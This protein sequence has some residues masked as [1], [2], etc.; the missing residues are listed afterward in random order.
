M[1]APGYV[2]LLLAFVALPV[3]AAPTVTAVKVDTA[4]R[5]DGRLTDACWQ[6]PAPIRDFVVL[7]QTKSAVNQTEAWVAYDADNLYLAVRAWDKDMD[8]LRATV[9]DRD[10]RVF[11]D[12]CLE[13]FIDTALDRFHFLHFACNPLGAQYD[14][15]G[16]GA[17]ESG[18]WNGVWSV[19]TA[20]AA[21]AWT[22]EFAIPFGTLGLA[23]GTGKTWGL[24]LCRTRPAEGELS[25]WSQTGGKFAVPQSFGNVNL[26][27]DWTP[28][29]VSLSVPQWGECV[30]GR[31]SFQCTVA[32]L[33]QKARDLT[34]DLEVSSPAEAPRTIS[35]PLNL[36]VGASQTLTVT[37]PIFQQGAHNLALTVADRAT[38][39]VV[40][41]VGCTKLVADMAAFSILK[42]FYRD[43]VTVAYTLR[44]PAE[45]LGR[46]G[47]AAELRRS[48]EAA[49]LATKRL[50]S[51]TER[52]GEIRFDTTSLPLGQYE[53]TSRLLRADGTTSVQDVLRFVQARD[54]H[55][56]SR[57][58][59]V[60]DDNM[61]IVEG[62]PFFPLGIYE[63]PGSER[64]MQALV[65]AGF[66]LCNAGQPAPAA[67]K[68]VLDKARQYGLRMWIPLSTQLD[69]SSDADK[70]RETLKTYADKL[71]S[72]P[73]LLMWESIDE[74]AWGS[75]NADGLYEGYS[76]LRT[77]DQQHPIWTNHAPRNLISTLA[78]FNRA[79]DA[80]GCDIYP[81][82]E[83][84]GHSDLPNKTISV[85]G[86]ET[87]K[88]VT[89]VGGE[90]PIFMVLQGFGWAELGPAANHDKAVM[91]TFEQSRFMA[92]DAIVHGSTGLLYWGTHY[93]RKPSP[94][95]S[96]LK[97]LISELAALQE[98]LASRSVTSSERASV[99]EPAGGVRLLH[100]RTEAGRN[101]L[102][103]VNET[104]G[105]VTATVKAP[106]IAASSLRRLF[107]KA[108]V[109]VTGGL[110][111]LPLAGYGVAVLS[112]DA[113]F[114]DV[115]KD[116][117][118]EWKN[119]K[120]VPDLA[121]Q[122]SQPGNLVRNGGFEVD[123]DDDLMPNLWTANY[124]FTV[125]LTEEQAHS[126]RFSLKI[127]SEEDGF[128]PLA[129]QRG[130]DT[131]GD[132][133][134]VISSWAK[135]SAP[136]VEFRIYVEWHL[137]DRY[138]GAIGP[139]TKGTGDWQ[140]VAV[141]LKT[142][143]DPQGGAYVVV[144][145]RGKGSVYFDDVAIEEAK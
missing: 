30:V 117:S 106:G 110:V 102:I 61:L 127:T 70:R 140:K 115:R 40:A 27:A 35:Q 133:A 12:D 134:Y 84:S 123:S 136:G 125:G 105:E 88:N 94:F 56:T 23:P 55:V 3:L 126:G 71:G 14:G 87:D 101:F 138:L 16:D 6:Q 28:Y 90:K 107:E 118:A 92:Y 29:F 18:D 72:H 130:L 104:P 122:L 57:L 15:A 143:P 9:K 22:A 86:D 82:P 81:V 17:G 119:A 1:R 73:A 108:T 91:P 49:V 114:R 39:R 80:S 85:T 43:D 142:T 25:C 60:R 121:A 4:P 46:F 131:K 62:K 137:G 54:P 144:Q 21:D 41:A 52:S 98:V 89:A 44:V 96:D 2:M 20:R 38:K 10:G 76:L 124:P 132:Q 24:N 67:A 74:P 128:T 116:F 33:G 97:S 47:L 42:S 65:E 19:K 113:S 93:T 37:F 79:T 58:V 103:V 112:D 145:L 66:N 7:G 45:E 32:N 139:W 50:G 36:A 95:F 100:K 78:Y 26:E 34:L 99:A 63:S 31:N 75:R 141:N 53:I 11:G 8:K 83:P 109:P 64:A 111:R 77:L 5:I 13:V 59:T 51:L 69:L 135:T 48:G 68:A 120:P 129:V